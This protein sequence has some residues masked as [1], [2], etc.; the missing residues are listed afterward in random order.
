MV[1]CCK[2]QRQTAVNNFSFSVC[3]LNPFSTG[4]HF[5]LQFWGY[6]EMIVLTLEK[7]SVEIFCVIVL[8][9][10][11]LCFHVWYT[12]FLCIVFRSVPFVLPYVSLCSFALCFFAFPPPCVL[13]CYLVFHYVLLRCPC[14]S[15]KHNGGSLKEVR[16][17]GAVYVTSPKTLHVNPPAAAATITC[18]ASLKH[19]LF[20]DSKQGQFGLYTH[21]QSCLVACTALFA[22]PA[23]SQLSAQS[24]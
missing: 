7:N 9:W 2:E 16:A 14:P 4:T 17:R 18:T 15:G 6:D 5:Y 3:H 19:V 22:P 20:I 12:A 1:Q 8:L 23:S 13:L 10:L 21:L 11:P 24:L